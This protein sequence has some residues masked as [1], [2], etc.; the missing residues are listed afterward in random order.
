MSLV[1]L[2]EYRNPEEAFVAGLLNQLPH[3][4]LASS[5][6]EKYAD[7]ENLIKSGTTLKK[8][9][10]N[11]FKVDYDEICRTIITSWNFPESIA[12]TILDVGGYKNPIFPYVKEAMYIIGGVF[13][14]KALAPVQIS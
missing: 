10:L 6:P 9:C 4:I 8:A 1:R 7:M 3:Q 11:I 13:P 2:K 5:Y 12:R 14:V